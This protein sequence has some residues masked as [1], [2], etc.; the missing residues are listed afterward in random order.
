MTNLL[1]RVQKLEREE[2]AARPARPIVTIQ[3]PDGT[4]APQ[5][6]QQEIDDAHEAGYPL[7]RVV[8]CKG[9]GPDPE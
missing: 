3:Q 9:P 5:Y 6:T 4:F 8:F 2:K 1:K 7:I